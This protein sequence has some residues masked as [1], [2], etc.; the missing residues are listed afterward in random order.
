MTK[1]KPN[2]TNRHIII[3]LSWP[4][5]SSVNAGVD[6]NSY[7]GIEFALTFPTVDD[8]TKKEIARFGTCCPSL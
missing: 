8:I 5:D 4:K 6:K 1:E 7:I 2:A 3:D